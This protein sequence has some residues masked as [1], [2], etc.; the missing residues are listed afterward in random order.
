MRKQIIKDEDI[1][2]RVPREK[3]RNLYSKVEPRESKKGKKKKKRKG[4]NKIVKN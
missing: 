4:Q 3:N 2:E 1:D